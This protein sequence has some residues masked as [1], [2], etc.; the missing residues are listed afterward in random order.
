MV[1]ELFFG[2]QLL[3]RVF[4][5][6]GILVSSELACLSDLSDKELELFH[7]SW[8]ETSVERRHEVI[9]QLVNLSEDNFG[10]D[11]TE[12]FV[13]CLQDSDETVR[14]QAIS[15]LELC[16]NHLVINPLIRLLR[17]DS[18]ATV[19]ATVA[20]ALARFAMLGE[21]GKLPSEYA[22][23]VY[24]ALLEV[25]DGVT[26]PVDVKRRALEA[27]APFSLPRVKE[28]I[29]EFYDS[30]DVK[31]KVSAI[32]AIGRN[33]DI[34]WLPVLLDELNSDEAEVRYEAAGACGELQADEAVPHLIKL[35]Y[36]EDDMVQE[37]AIR[38]LGAI[39]GYKA[40]QALN[41]LVNDSRLHIQQTAKSAIDE[42]EFWESPLSLEF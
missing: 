32:Y 31:F 23:D 40:K 15:G 19:R 36:D 42:L 10:L 24:L 37:A 25:L 12:L 21:L 3:E 26:E 1:D 11:F 41:N 8:T 14:I 5:S 7:K 34:A 16:E 4:A 28:L 38:A 30:G 27:I 2:R 35:I 39:G 22:D 17:E 18:S 13:D 29:K 9:S 6:D 33:C 20:I